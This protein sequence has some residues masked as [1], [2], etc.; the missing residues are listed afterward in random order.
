MAQQVQ[1]DFHRQWIH[2][3]EGDMCIY[4]NTK[5]VMCDHQYMCG[6][7]AHLQNL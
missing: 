1:I 2:S 3:N 4:S 6:R 5:G 7:H